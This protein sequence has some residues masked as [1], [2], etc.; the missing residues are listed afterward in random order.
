MS[1]KQGFLTKKD[2]LRVYVQKTPIFKLG[3][4]NSIIVTHQKTL[5]IFSRF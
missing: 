5:W 1:K 2:C 3:C 4:Y